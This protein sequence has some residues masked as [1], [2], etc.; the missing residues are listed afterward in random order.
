MVP[1]LGDLGKVTDGKHW[2]T[3]MATNWSVG[4]KELIKAKYTDCECS[5]QWDLKSGDS[6]YA[7][8]MNFKN[9]VGG[10]KLE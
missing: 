4:E 3:S 5:P 10:L 8:E 7:S 9:I 2:W 1:G 6:A